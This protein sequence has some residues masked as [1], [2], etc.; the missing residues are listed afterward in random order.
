VEAVTAT[1]DSLDYAFTRSAVLSLSRG[2]AK[3]AAG[4]GVTVNAVLIGVTMTEGTES[5]LRAMAPSSEM[6]LYHFGA[7]ALKERYPTSIDGRVH[8]VKEVTDLVVY[9]CSEFSS[10]MTGGC[11]S[12]GRRNLGDVDL[13]R[14]HLHGD[15]GWP[16]PT[17]P[18]KLTPAPS[19]MPSG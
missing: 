3:V 9:L 1:P 2:L 16:P 8:T 10:V 18:E 5:V 12:R 4:S 13:N 17:S 6:D 7:A 15:I 14:R 11:L 19:E